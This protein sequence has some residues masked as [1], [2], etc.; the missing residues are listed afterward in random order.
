MKGS[1]RAACLLVAVVVAAAYGYDRHPHPCED[2]H[3]HPW[4]EAEI[5]DALD[6]EATQVGSPITDDIYIDDLPIPACYRCACAQQKRHRKHRFQPPSAEQ[7]L[8]KA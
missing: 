2:Y 1:L 8:F 3:T 7:G 5:T 6:H 4:T